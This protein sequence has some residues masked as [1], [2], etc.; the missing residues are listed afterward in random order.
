MLLNCTRFYAFIPLFIFLISQR[1]IYFVSCQIARISYHDVRKHHNFLRNS[2]QLAR[3]LIRLWYLRKGIF[4]FFLK[5]SRDA[6][7]CTLLGSGST[8]TRCTI[9]RLILNWKPHGGQ[10]SVQINSLC[11][12]LSRS[13][14]YHYGR[15]TD[16]TNSRQS[17]RLDCRRRVPTALRYCAT[18]HHR[19]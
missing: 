19:E 7:G 6:R 5:I 8:R 4:S 18:G 10:R 15:R 2:P 12:S 14:V 17:D 9:A 13:E 11:L 16:N 1:S 3:N